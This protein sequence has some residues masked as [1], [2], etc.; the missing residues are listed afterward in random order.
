MTQSSFTLQG[1]LGTFQRFAFPTLVAGTLI[2]AGCSDDGPTAVPDPD[3]QPDPVLVDADELQRI[4]VTDAST[5]TGSVFPVVEGDAL[6]SFDL[7]GAASYVYSSTSGRFAILQQRN[8]NLVQF[9]DG[10][11]WTH[12][13]HG[14]RH[15]PQVLSFEIRDD[16]PTHPSANEDWISVFFDGSGVAAW[17]NEADLF[18]GN[19][20][21]AFELATGGPH[22]S[23]SLAVVHGGSS[24]FAVAPLNPEGGLPHGVEVYDGQGELV[25]ATSDCPGMHGNAANG[26]TAVFGC[27]DGFVL[28][29]A[30][31]SGADVSKYV[32]EGEFEGLGLRSA[33]AATG[34]S[35]ILGRFSALPGQPART[36]LGLVD[37]ESGA[38]RPLPPLSSGVL[39]HW[40]AVEP[41]QN[42][43]VVLGTD[44]TL[45][46]Y[47]GSSAAL[48]RT[49][50]GVVP[51][52]TGDGD[53]THQVAVADGLAAVASPTTGEVVLVD[54][55]AGSIL[56]RVSVGGAPSRL[57]ILG[58]RAR[59]IY[60]VEE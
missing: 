25:G 30:S 54:T 12:H 46:I 22:H 56:R 13:D 55:D 19:P 27:R 6:M 40:R 11:V 1:L 15:D 18:E 2:L 57:A 24:Y 58:A 31:S 9:L 34:A 8:A 35:F 43:A 33:W 52:L 37:V 3:P 23:G 16:L 48:E 41:V 10:G 4:V 7:G 38:L 45:Y 50:E 60:E 51:A 17:V 49:V 26:A 36:V 21:V 39:D 5:A 32:P 59:G 14:H 42:R 28:I 20:R 53:A 29:Q 44:G 47:S